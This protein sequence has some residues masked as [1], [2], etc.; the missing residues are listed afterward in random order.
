MSQPTCYIGVAF[1]IHASFPTQRALILS[2]N[3]HFD[4]PGWGSTATE[5]VNGVGTSSLPFQSSPTGFSPMGLFL[6]IVY[7]AQIH[8]SIQNL[9]DLIS[10]SNRASAEDR[11]M[12][13]G[14]DDIPWG[15]DKYV[16][17]ALLRLSEGR[18][19][20]LTRLGRDSLAHF[21]GGRIRDLLRTR[22]TPGGDV[23]PIVSL[24]SGDVSFV[25]LAEVLS[26][27]D[28]VLSANGKFTHL[29][30][31]TLSHDFT[32]TDGTSG[33]SATCDPRRANLMGWN[34]KQMPVLPKEGRRRGIDRRLQG[35]LVMAREGTKDE[36]RLQI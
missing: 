21:I 36:P 10:G 27:Y 26:C 4:G 34:K 31:I 25:Y 3:P 7:V 15:T 13:R 11:T 33:Q 19:L 6:G 23:F 22:C 24:D 17:L 18:C 9:K 28:A 32:P 2:E 12:V 16:V 14:T 5:T 1:Y 30:D 29:W 35:S 8:V 20:R